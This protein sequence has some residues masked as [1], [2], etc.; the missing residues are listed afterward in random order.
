MNSLWGWIHQKALQQ[1]AQTSHNP[2]PFLS[3]PRNTKFIHY[4]L[5]DKT[6]SPVK[7]VKFQFSKCMYWDKPS[8]AALSAA[9]NNQIAAF[10]RLARK[11]EDWGRN[12]VAFP[13]SPA[14]SISTESFW[15]FPV[16][17]FCKLQ[18]NQK[19]VSP[20]GLNSS[21]QSEGPQSN[22]TEQEIKQSLYIYLPFGHG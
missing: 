4:E 20:L 11:K 18:G 6:N 5:H 9:T 14:L 13:F 22:T 15:N 3:D 7:V 8:R 2:L 16:P 17:K 10:N 12:P 21:K 19:N 1:T